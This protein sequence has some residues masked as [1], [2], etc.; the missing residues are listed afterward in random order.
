LEN[1]FK[2]LEQKDD[3]FRLEQAKHTRRNF[4]RM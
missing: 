2:K 3:N 4:L 1:L